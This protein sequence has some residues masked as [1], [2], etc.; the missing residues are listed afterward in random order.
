[1]FD[2]IISEATKTL[3][4]RKSQ[5]QNECNMIEKENVTK[6]NNLEFELNK[7]RQ[8][9]D[10]QIH[11]V[12]NSLRERE[13]AIRVYASEMR[14]LDK[15]RQT[16]AEKNQELIAKENYLRELE[17]SLEEIRKELLDKQDQAAKTIELY[18]KRLEQISQL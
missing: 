18:E 15:D 4:S 5:L 13:A 14:D 16:L 3:E 12:E 17:K 10:A 8:E 6:R 2:S 9:F 11:T 1:M 7:R